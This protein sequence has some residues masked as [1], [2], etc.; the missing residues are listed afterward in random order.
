VKLYHWRSELL[1]NYG[2]GWLIA[3]AATPEEAREKIRAGFEANDRER[4]EWDWHFDDEDA[5]E[6][7]AKRREQLETDLR[8]EPVASDHLYIP[9]SE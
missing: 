7:R 5:R 1:Q 3:V 6:S 9:G 8:P 4:H 2:D